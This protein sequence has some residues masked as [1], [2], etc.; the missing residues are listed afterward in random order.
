MESKFTGY[1]QNTLQGCQ[2]KN[3]LLSFGPGKDV[4]VKSIIRNPTL[5]GGYQIYINGDLL[6]LKQLN[7]KIEL[8]YIVANSVMPVNVKFKIKYFV[9]PPNPTQ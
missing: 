5:K 4:A 2:Q 7:T 1:I 8:N 9:R 3:L 6:V